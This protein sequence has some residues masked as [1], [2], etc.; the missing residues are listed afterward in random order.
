MRKENLS[1]NLDMS[2]SSC[3][4]RACARQVTAAARVLPHGVLDFGQHRAPELPAEVVAHEH[5]QHRVEAAVGQRKR[6][7]EL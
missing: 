4:H 7:S 6:C 2:G 5:V 3:V 1:G